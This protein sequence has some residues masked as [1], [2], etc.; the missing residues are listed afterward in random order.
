MCVSSL[1][2]SPAAPISRGADRGTQAR[3]I[4]GKMDQLVRHDAQMEGWG[5][6]ELG[7]AASLIH[8]SFKRVSLPSEFP[9]VPHVTA[10][11]EKPG[12]ATQKE[13]AAAPR[14]WPAA[15][16]ALASQEGGLPRPWYWHRR[17]AACRGPQHGNPGEGCR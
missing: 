7:V 6:L 4:A 5:V 2:P 10:G 15:A 14:P 17:K 16:M 3:P 11:R 13:R 1:W 8:R 9:S 12:L